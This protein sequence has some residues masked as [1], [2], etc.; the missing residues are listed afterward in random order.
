MARRRRKP[1]EPIK[2]DMTPMI[3]VTFQLLIF[4]M[5]T[6]KFKTLEG[7]LS[8]YLPKD[9]GVNTTQAEPKEKLEIKLKVI[10]EGTKLM[11]RHNQLWTGVGAFRYGPDRVVQYSVGPRTTRDL[12]ELAKRLQELFQANPEQPVTLDALPGI[13]YDDV[14]Q[15]LDQAINAGYRDITFVGYD[16]TEEQKPG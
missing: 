11:P 10:A 14:V 7:K 3:D 8:A 12:K 1:E 6:I 4:F 15:V 13:V 2:G 5:L 9:V 16:I